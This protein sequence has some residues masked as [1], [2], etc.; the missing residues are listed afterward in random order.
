MTSGAGKTPTIIHLFALA[1]A[2]VAILARTLLYPDDL[3]LT[4]LTITMIVIISIRG[5][6]KSEVVA[7]VALLGTF[8]GFLIGVNGAK[9]ITSIIHDPT[10]AAAITTAIVSELIGW[11][12]Y[13]FVRMRTSES[14]AKDRSPI[15]ISTRKVMIFAIAILVIRAV[16]TQIFNSP[17][18]TEGGLHIELS[19]LANNSFAIIAIICGN[20]I[21]MGAMRHF[22]FATNHLKTLSTI[23]FNAIFSLL[24]SLV[25]YYNFPL[26]N[27]VNFDIVILLRLYAVV[28]LINIAIYAIFGLVSYASKNHRELKRER[29]RKQYAQFQ[30]ERLKLQINPHFLFNSL[31]I[32][33][34]LV[35]DQK[36]EQARSFIRKLAGIYRYMLQTDN[37]KI[38]T[39]EQELDFATKY[40]DLLKE[41]FS[42]GLI[43]KVDI[44]PEHSKRGIV[45]CS[46]QL[47]IENATKHNI[48][49]S[50]HPLSI[51]ISVCDNY[52]EVRNNIQ[53]R[54]SNSESTKIGLE[55]I[56]Q[57]YLNISNQNIVINRNE[58]Y[59]S[60]KLPLL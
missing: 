49:D 21:Y 40:I 11:G 31:N 44:A 16:Y 12:A 3:L 5:G 45:P 52:I 47:L 60:V 50:E 42:E 15:T 2:G 30:Y 51:S 46:L 48:V 56:R 28:F 32:L 23:L 26:G 43:V 58:E 7:A 19:R 57:Q 36:T 29:E 33:D 13:T 38:A 55:N 14:S 18:F 27:S 25:I 4:L 9:Y 8:S 35:E 34:Y 22:K 10:L 59:F 53:L 6:L 41:R 20:I 54:F 24:I 17:Y 37:N 1:H 39:I